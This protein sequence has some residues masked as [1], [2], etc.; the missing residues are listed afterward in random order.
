MHDS[1]PVGVPRLGDMDFR[2][3]TEPQQGATFGDQLRIAE[4]AEALGFDAFFRSDHFLAMDLRRGG[5]PGP[6]DSWVTLGAI[7]TRTSR[8]RLGTLVSSAT[9]RHPSLLAIQVAQVD[10]M[11]G[12]R[13]E[14]G[15]GTG[16]FEAE[17]RAYGF[18]FPAKRFDRFEEQLEVITGLWSTPVGETFSHS[19]EHYTLVDSPALPKPTQPRIPIIVGGGGPERTPAIAARFA[20]E[21]NAFSV[22]TGFVADRIA[23]VRAA[24]EAIGRDHSAM[25]FSIA[26]TTAVGPTEADVERRA[27]AAQATADRLRKT[28]I[29]GSAAEAVDAIG[30]LAEI[31]VTRFYLQ[32]QDM[33]DLDQVEF[34]ATE[35]LPQLR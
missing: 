34:I 4:A 1:P 31:G 28:G 3:F 21:Y 18:P 8:I 6:T 27:D 15:L 22:D 26:A 23:R 20:D 7:A 29:A 11:S 5:L 30:R 32:L 2:I 12:G 9:F 25:V 35:V 13:V 19:G 33:R 14:L 17:H 10:E 24:A 16:W